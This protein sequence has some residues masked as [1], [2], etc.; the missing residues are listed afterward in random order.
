MKAIANILNYRREQRLQK[1]KKKKR[2]RHYML[3]TACY[4]QK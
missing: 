1:E 4:D 3:P 2:E